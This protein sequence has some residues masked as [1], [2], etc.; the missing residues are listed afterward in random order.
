MN[1]SSRVQITPGSSNVV[2]LWDYDQNCHMPKACTF[3]L[4]MWSFSVTEAA[5]LHQKNVNFGYQASNRALNQKRWSSPSA[6]VVSQPVLT[7]GPCNQPTNLTTPSQVDSVHSGVFPQW[8]L[9]TLLRG[10]HQR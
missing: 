6:D 8:G 5:S 2:P 7:A 3:S 9:A 1:P 10:A 4:V